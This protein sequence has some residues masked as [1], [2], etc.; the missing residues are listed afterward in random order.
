MSF[1]FS[2]LKVAQIGPNISS[3]FKRDVLEDQCHSGGNVCVCY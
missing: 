1:E 2:R 3:L